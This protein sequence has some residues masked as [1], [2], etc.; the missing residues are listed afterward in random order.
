MS[1]CR[2]RRHP[3][4]RHYPGSRG[5]LWFSSHD[6]STRDPSCQDLL[7]P[8]SSSTIDIRSL[9]RDVTA[10]LASALVISR[11]DYCN[12][13]LTHLP[14]STPASQ[15]TT[16]ESPQRWC[17]VGSWIG[18][19]WSRDTG[20]VWT[21]LVT[22]CRENQV[23]TLPFGIPCSKWSCTVE[24]DRV[25]YSCSQHPRT[26]LSPLSWEARSGCS[27]FETGLIRAGI[28]RRSPRALNGLP[29]DIRLITDTKLFKKKLKTFLF[30]S[31]YH[32][33][34]QWNFVWIEQLWTMYV[35]GMTLNSS[36]VVL[37]MTL[38]SCGAIEERIL[39]VLLQFALLHS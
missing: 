5:L 9:G 27:A 3:T 24:S 6:E 18:T 21:A 22:N 36:V 26:R 13:V 30:N 17:S 1:H 19:T 38:N 10:R 16:P 34:R 33:I 35:L 4:S 32:G 31:A 8:S 39:W 37:S 7:P 12:S 29:V 2:H 25:G 15:Y 14:A 11:L 28:F 20:D 23:Q